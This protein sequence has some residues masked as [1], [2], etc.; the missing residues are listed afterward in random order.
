MTT[1][2]PQ[3]HPQSPSPPPVV[4]KV[5]QARDLIAMVPYRLGF[6]P[7]RSLV[8]AGLRGPRSRVGLVLRVDLPAPA[9]VAAVA[10][11]VAGYLKGDAAFRAVA[12]VYDDAAAP[13]T[14]PRRDHQELLASVR[15]RLE[16]RDIELCEAWLVGAK[17]YWSLTCGDAG[18]CPDEGW[19]VEDL[20]SSQVSAEMVVRGVGVAPS[21]AQLLPDLSPVPAD[22]MAAVQREVRAAAVPSKGG[23]ADAAD[24]RRQGVAAWLALVAGTAGTG[25]QVPDAQ[26]IQWVGAVLARLHDPWVR[27][28]VLLTAVP[29]T[30]NVPE[31]LASKGP[32]PEAHAVMNQVFGPGQALAPDPDLLA[33]ARAALVQLV[34]HASGRGRAAPLA[35]LAWA[36]WWEGDGASAG[37]LAEAALSEDRANGLAALVRGAVVA[38]MAPAWAAADRARDVDGL[39]GHG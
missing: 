7:E 3:S 12:V 15:A 8:L 4:L 27:D 9:G 25:P 24:W 19:P 32:H 22:R 26:Q 5:S 13:G 16:T 17:R 39:D 37:D 20:S 11:Q 14:G 38:G 21:R 1:N 33:A 6:V 28:A 29:G 2:L 36:A 10:E 34:R 31:M 23:P 18:C 35:V 30:G